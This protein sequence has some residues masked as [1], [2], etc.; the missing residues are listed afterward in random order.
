MFRF[1]WL[2]AFAATS[3][4]YAVTAA[5]SITGGDAG[6][7][8]THSWGLGVAHPPGYPLWSMLAFVFAKVFPIGEVAWRYNWLSGLYNAGAAIVLGRLVE[9]ITKD[10]WAA[11][12]TVSLLCFSPLLWRYSI[13]TE[14]F[15]LNQLLV[16]AWLAL[17]WNHL[18]APGTR[19]W[20][21]L[22][23]FA[24]L[25]VSHHHTSAMVTAPL[26]VIL[27][28]QERSSI[29]SRLPQA[30]LW[31]AVGLLPY[32]YLIWAAQSVPRMAWGDTSSFGG[33]VF[34]FL[35]REYGT[36]QLG[37]ELTGHAN[38][39]LF[40]LGYFLKDL[41]ANSLGGIGVWLGFSAI[42]HALRQKPGT[43]RRFVL[44][45]GVGCAAYLLIFCY[46]A[47]LS[48]DKPLGELVQARFWLLG[49][50]FTSLWAGL[51]AALLPSLIRVRELQKKLAV[52]SLL[53][54]VPM[55]IAL[56]NQ[57]GATQFRDYA[58]A[59]LESLP[60]DSVL[61]F[62]GDHAYGALYYVQQ[63]MGLRQ[64]VQILHL[65]F[66]SRPWSRRWAAANYPSVTIP[67]KGIGLYGAPGFQ[68]RDL[69][70]SNR[71]PGREIFVLNGIRAWEKSLEGT[72][73]RLPWGM[74]EWIVPQSMPNQEAFPIWKKASDE[75]FA[76]FQAPWKPGWPLGDKKGQHWENIVA[77]EYLDARHNFAVALANQVQSGQGELTLSREALSHLEYMK[78]VYP[79][80]HPTF[81]K[82]YGLVLHQLMQLD[83]SFKPRVIDAWSFYL[84]N[85]T[86]P[87]P[88]EPAI[89]D[90]I[91]RLER[92]LG[93]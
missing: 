39:V 32:G 86:A 6:E 79:D 89:R 42:R 10:F 53:S 72:Y 61:L 12:F 3:A 29:R 74:A 19:S 52:A 92:E 14:V 20:A 2:V 83:P 50:L 87:D 28:W 60:R 4:L 43:Y 1:R 73:N 40:R 24:G 70:E 22:C 16:A 81:W 80:A 55:G 13:V 71:R 37:N 26:L 9:K 34:H 31:G 88:Q 78:P 33:M 38:E 67:L 41:P 11:L 18:Q 64:D 46:L 91:S 90:I 65:N 58:R 54:L 76:K 66:L 21:L 56:E 84:R 75:F 63:V 45:S 25:G 27:L 5:P 68:I 8:L 51:G 30:L 57:R 15:G 47:N 49:L 93:R 69:V 48:L 77:G 44:L 59:L 7:L 36:F 62:E 35:R 17:L 85:K 82:N 23:L